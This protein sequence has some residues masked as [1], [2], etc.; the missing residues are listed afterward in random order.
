MT[1]LVV[2][3]QLA[4]QEDI[5]ERGMATFVEVGNALATIRAN[6]LYRGSYG[7]FE[8]YCQQRW[9]W[10]RQ[11]SNRV[12]GAAS[13]VTHLEPTG[14]ILPANEA[15]A[16]ELARLPAEQQREVW[17]GAVAESEATGEP[18]TARQVEERVSRAFPK[19]VG[20]RRKGFQAP[21]DKL[22]NHLDEYVGWLE[23]MDDETV[24]PLSFDRTLGTIIDTLQAMREMSERASRR[25]RRID[26]YS[27]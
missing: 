17:S 26:E 25:P 24:L 6:R 20:K 4:S 27:A 1:D 15:Q 11:H 12:I 19:P 2:H 21:E 7:T 5:I 23:Q 9:G 3:D 18:I 16:R 14:S 13:V 22:R 10:T 8:E